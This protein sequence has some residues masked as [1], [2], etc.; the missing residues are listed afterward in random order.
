M[1]ILIGKPIDRLT[2]QQR[3]AVKRWSIRELETETGK[4][5]DYHYELEDKTRALIVLAKHL[6][7]F[8]EQLM[9]RA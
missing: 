6:G 2:E 3:T 4:V 5:L 9:F 7:M 1:E 8:N